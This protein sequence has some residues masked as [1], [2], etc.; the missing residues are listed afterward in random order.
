MEVAGV[1]PIDGDGYLLVGIILADDDPFLAQVVGG[2]G[3][4]A[5]VRTSGHDHVR[6]DGSDVEEDVL[7]PLHDGDLVVLGGVGT[8]ENEDAD[9]GDGH[10]RGG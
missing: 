3:E 2:G 1:A 7:R 9:A 6:I 8:A 10:G 4:D 5:G